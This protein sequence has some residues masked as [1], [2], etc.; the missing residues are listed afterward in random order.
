MQT[1]SASAYQMFILW[2]D[3]LKLES[4][5][6]QM[7]KCK[8]IHDF[9]ASD[10]FDGFYWNWVEVE[11]ME[12]ILKESTVP[13][14]VSWRICRQKWQKY[15]R[16]GIY[17]QQDIHFPSGS[18]GAIEVAQH[19]DLIFFSV[20]ALNEIAVYILNR[21]FVGISIEML[22]KLNREPPTTK[23]CIKM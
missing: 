16:N 8:R 18:I 4:V 20:V 6:R 19:D 13:D 5:F 9:H 22:T 21:I 3:A 23:T 2:N 1:A 15:G 12:A 17:R 7:A 11:S 10:C 14:K